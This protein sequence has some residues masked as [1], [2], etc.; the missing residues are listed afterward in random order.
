M[1][2][3]L[4]VGDPEDVS[5]LVGFSLVLTVLGL[6]FSFSTT[7]VIALKLLVKHSKYVRQITEIGTKM[8]IHC[9]SFSFKHG[10]THLIL[11]ES[12]THA[13]RTC[14][15]SHLWIDRSDVQLSI[16][17]F[18]IANRISFNKEIDIYFD[19]KLT[20]ISDTEDNDAPKILANDI[21][22]LGTH[23]PIQ[24]QLI[25]SFQAQMKLHGRFKIS[26]VTIIYQRTKTGGGDEQLVL[27]SARSNE[28]APK[29]GVASG[30]A[31]SSSPIRGAMS[32]SVAGSDFMATGTMG[33]TN[34][35]GGYNNYNANMNVNSNLQPKMA[36]V[37]SNSSLI[38]GSD[39]FEVAVEL[40][41]HDAKYG[42]TPTAG[43]PSRG[44]GK[45]HGNMNGN[46]IGIGINEGARQSRKEGYGTPL[47]ND[48]AAGYSHES[49]SDE[50]EDDKIAYATSGGGFA[51]ERRY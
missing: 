11:Q 17:V 18:Y 2:Y 38:S 7:A 36:A 51:G 14:E 21:K 1:A 40:A 8:T 15:H 49:D 25:H 50:N 16:E 35:M 42:I 47:V 29:S 10:Y 31:S 39:D 32:S 12:I 6:V 28:A 46:G 27:V 13:L 30:S 48:T 24:K 45:G 37:K 3:I 33:N 23:S 9:D 44:N 19:T 43:G 34:S 20:C 4:D 41:R 26:N 5:L 22:Q